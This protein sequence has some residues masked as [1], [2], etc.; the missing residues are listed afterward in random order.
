MT[1]WCRRSRQLDIC[2]EE[3][4]LRDPHT[5]QLPQGRSRTFN[6]AITAQSKEVKPK[7]RN[8]CELLQIEMLLSER[9]LPFSLL[10]LTFDAGA[11][12]DFL[13]LVS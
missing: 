5:I 11:A 4:V 9:L 12:G 7:D 13:F 10:Y 2:D 1:K 6:N 8:N 3:I